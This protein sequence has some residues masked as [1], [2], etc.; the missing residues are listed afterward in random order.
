MTSVAGRQLCLLSGRVHPELAQEVAKV[1]GTKLCGIKLSNFANGEISCRIN[2]S[3]RGSD[4][5]IIQS[6]AGNV[7]DALME[8]AIIIDAAKRASAASITAVC[9]FLGYARQ[10]RKSNGREP[11]T[12]KLAVDLLAI[13]GA[14][15]IM[16]IDLHSGQTQGFFNGPFDHLIAMP[17]MVDYIKHTF[18]NTD[19]V[20]IVSPD[21][22]RVKTAE[23]YGSALNCDIA[24]IHKQRST[25]KHNDVEAKY[26]IGEVTGKICIVID[27]MIDTAGTICSAADLLAE[28]GA[29]AIYGI[30]THGVF[31]DPAI[32]RIE[33]SAFSKVVV[34][35]TL[36]EHVGKSS[37]IETL[38]IAPLLGNAIG[39]IFTGQSVSKLFDGK[40]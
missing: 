15:R 12:A 14:D 29:K 17:T 38:S 25:T 5:F 4:V 11:I 32:E 9:P 37:K 8:Q 13:A 35:N 2:E 10:D 26:L 16:S 3:V 24:I 1:L 21:A 39:A 20:V 34:T 27:D 40:N 6:H 33:K 31:S 23:R 28:H 18:K 36:P 22:G 30:A 7:N 19:D